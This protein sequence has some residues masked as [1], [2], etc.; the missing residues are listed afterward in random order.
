VA[1]TIIAA[2]LL[3]LTNRPEN[4]PRALVDTLHSRF[5]H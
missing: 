5:G 1:I 3:L 2:D 4:Q